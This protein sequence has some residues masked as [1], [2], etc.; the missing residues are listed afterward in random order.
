MAGLAHILLRDL[1]LDGFTGFVECGEQ[2][3]R[4]FADLEIDG[5]VFD[6]DDDVLVELAV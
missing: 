3:R 5:A 2:W 4:G 6:L 1:K